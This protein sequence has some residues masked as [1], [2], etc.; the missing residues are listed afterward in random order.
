MASSSNS[1]V[2][3]SSP[4][5][6]A[7][8]QWLNEI[9]QVVD[10]KL[11]LGFLYDGVV[12]PSAPGTVVHTW[13]EVDEPELEI[14]LA[15]D[16]VRHVRYVSVLSSDEPL[17]RRVVE[18]L[19]QRVAFRTAA[20]LR[21]DLRRT[22]GSDPDQYVHLALALDQEADPESLAL[23]RQGL[24]SPQL[25]TRLAAG[26]AAAILR[27]PELAADLGAALEQETNEEAR[28]ALAMARWL[29]GGP[30]SAA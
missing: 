30:D 13:S 7:I 14:Q 4:R 26:E 6:E 9:L 19:R 22:G 1:L 29:V 23:I 24:R 2:L 25:E 15:C 12:E 16:D 17:R 3:K 10:Q 5:N 11:G 21:E 27:A 28:R 18:E 8:Q 20:E